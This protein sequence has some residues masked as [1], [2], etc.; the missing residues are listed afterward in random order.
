MSV[1]YTAQGL[2]RH[3]S[4]I[5]ESAVSSFT[6]DLD[7]TA[8]VSLVIA[9]FAFSTETSNFNARI[10]AMNSTAV[11]DVRYRTWTHSTTSTFGSTNATQTVTNYFNLGA[12]STDS[13]TGEWMR[14]MIWIHNSSIGYSTS[15]AMHS[16][17]L[18]GNVNYEDNGGNPV[19]S[20]FTSRLIDDTELTGLRFKAG[21]GNIAWHR[22]ASWSMADG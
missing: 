16:V 17:T 7:N 6:I 5:N 21:S 8:S 2:L 11:A 22:A 9:Q 20:L 1:D 10:E 4:S 15:P 12:A 3:D 13:F 14:C 19:N 18:Y